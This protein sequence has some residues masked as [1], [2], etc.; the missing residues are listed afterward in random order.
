[1][2]SAAFPPKIPATDRARNF[3]KGVDMEPV[4]VGTSALDA[5]SAFFQAHSGDVL[6]EELVGHEGAQTAQAIMGIRELLYATKDNYDS[7]I[8]AADLVY[9]HHF[10]RSQ[11]GSV[12]R[13]DKKKDGAGPPMKPSVTAGSR[14]KHRCACEVI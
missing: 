14:Y 10:A 2:Y 13:Y 12:S 11:A 6:N 3:T 9:A 4:S 7:R 8:K 5:I 1:M